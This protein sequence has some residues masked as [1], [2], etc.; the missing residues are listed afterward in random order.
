MKSL[1]GIRKRHRRGYG[2]CFELAFKAIHEEPGA[3][4][5]F[6]LVHGT[7]APESYWRWRIARWRVR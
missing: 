6:T 7:V 3:D 2:R 1:K 5:H 4:R